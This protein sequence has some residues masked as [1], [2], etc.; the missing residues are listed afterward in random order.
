MSS[1]TTYWCDRC[2]IE[3]DGLEYVELK[4]ESAEDIRPTYKLYELCDGCCADV[5]SAVEAVMARAGIA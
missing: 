4:K 1:K 3:V 5:F 2:G